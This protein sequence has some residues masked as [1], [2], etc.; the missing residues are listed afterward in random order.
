MTPM[1]P[2]HSI[3][4]F[5]IIHSFISFLVSSYFLFSPH[6]WK[7]WE[8]TF[9]FFFFVSLLCSWHCFIFLPSLVELG[10]FSFPAFSISRF[11]QQIFLHFPFPSP[12]SRLL[13]CL[14]LHLF[15]LPIPLIPSL[16]ILKLDCVPFTCLSC[17]NFLIFLPLI[18]I[19]FLLFFCSFISH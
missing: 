15:L 13:V 11:S 16:I 8:R 9:F 6:C 10:T 12:Q 2:L 17:L 18:Q 14:P 5:I 19:F 3:H 1:T 4:S 7:W